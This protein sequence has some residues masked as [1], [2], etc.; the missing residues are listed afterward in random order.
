MEPPRLIQQNIK[1]YFVFFNEKEID[2]VYLNEVKSWQNENLTD[3]YFVVTETRASKSHGSIILAKKETTIIEV[4]AEKFDRHERGKVFEI[5]TCFEV[6]V[7]GHLWVIALYNSPGRDLN[8]SEIFETEMKNV[9][10]V[11]ISKLHIK[12]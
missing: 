10:S 6:P 2:I 9:L 7:I 5:K 8:L 3:D 12:S 11:E 1:K 4:E